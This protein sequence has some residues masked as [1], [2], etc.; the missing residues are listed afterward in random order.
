MLR[1]SS[2][3]QSAATRF[4][5][6]VKIGAFYIFGNLEDTEETIRS[7]IAYA[8]FL[9]T[10]YAQF[11]ISTPYPGTKFYDE[12]KPKLTETKLDNFDIYTPTFTHPHL[13]HD[14]ILRLKEEAYSGYYFRW[15]WLRRY[16]AESLRQ[17]SE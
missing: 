2:V 11:T 8:K 6:S 13:S 3:S 14:T 12:M 7:T 10:S 9:N 4:F 1:W 17:W 15:K 16:M 5:S